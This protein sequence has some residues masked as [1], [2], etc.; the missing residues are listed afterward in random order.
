MATLTYTNTIS[1]WNERSQNLNAPLPNYPHPETNKDF[2][3]LFFNEKAS[4]ISTKN[5][6]TEITRKTV[7]VGNFIYAYYYM[8]FAW[9]FIT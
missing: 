8:R 3:L 5:N 6:I 7:I 1:N 4:G 2:F 9:A